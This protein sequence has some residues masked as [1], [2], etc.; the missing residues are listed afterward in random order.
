[1][2]FKIQINTDKL[3]FEICLREDDMKDI[4]RIDDDDDDDDNRTTPFKPNERKLNTPGSASHR[5]STIVNRRDADDGTYVVKRKLY[6]YYNICKRN[7]K[8]V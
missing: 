1:M 3:E 2:V 4:K 7:G 5:H 8:A 6:R